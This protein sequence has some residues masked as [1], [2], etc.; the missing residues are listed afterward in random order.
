MLEQLVARRTHPARRGGARVQHGQRRVVP[1][2]TVS[3]SNAHRDSRSVQ[4]HR[5]RH[6]A[7]RAAR[8]RSRSRVAARASRAHGTCR[9]SRVDIREVLRGEIVCWKVDFDIPPQPHGRHIDQIRE[10]VARVGRAGE[11]RERGRSRLLGDRRGGGRDPRHAA[12]EGAPARGRRGRRDPRRRRRDLGIRASSA[13]RTCAA[14]S[15]RTGDGTVRAAHGLLPVPAP[16]TLKLLEGHRVSPGPEG[17]GELVT[18]TGAALVRVL[19]TG[20]AAGGV[21]A[22]PQRIRRGHEGLRRP[23]ERAAHHP[24]RRRCRARAV[25]ASVQRSSRAT[26]TT[27]RPSTSPPSRTERASTGAL[28]VMLARGRR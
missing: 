14:A 8:R 11:V 26:W 2:L 9:T 16:A 28:D 15:I 20:P 18:P 6:D 19:S 25:R 22:A 12:R 21:R 7:R 1:L 27:C 3:C 10:L 24:R 4:R 13:S 23:R 17:A 5:R